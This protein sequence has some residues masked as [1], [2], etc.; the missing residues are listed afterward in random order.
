VADKVIEELVHP[1]CPSCAAKDV[2]IEEL[3][4][5]GKDWIRWKEIAMSRIAALE[6]VAKAV[7]NEMD[8][9]W[10]MPESVRAALSAAGKGCR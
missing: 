9:D 8:A 2:R 6:K 1:P 3:E 7:Q 10:G 5:Q 4:S